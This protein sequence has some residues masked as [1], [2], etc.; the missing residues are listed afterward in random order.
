M[1]PRLGPRL[2]AG[3]GTPGRLC[4][5]LL[6]AAAAGCA[7]EPA[8]PSAGASGAATGNRVVVLA[9]AAAEM[10]EALDLLDRVVG[11]GQFGPW[12]AALE[13]L[14]AVGGYDSPNVE[15]LLE[16]DCDLLLT[17][18]SDA[19]LD[20][21]HRLRSVGIAV[22]TL[23][24]S[25]YE[26]IFDSLLRVGEIFGREADA[27][28]LERGIRAELASLAGRASGVPPRRVLVVVGRDPLYVAGPGSHVDE[29]IR[30][31]GGSNVAH[32]ALSP[33]QQLSLEV[34]L[35]RMPEVIVDLSDNRAAAPRGR[36]PGPWGEWAFLPAV[37]ENRVYWIEPARLVIPG[38]RLPEMALLMGQLIHPERFGEVPPE[39]SGDGA[40]PAREGS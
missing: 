24:T 34:V 17:A 27:R 20:A 39:I 35:E 36:L 37:R 30:L 7:D 19:A 2:L 6:L 16:L 28:E 26:G 32:D 8:R 22:E 11:V 5:V 21:H 1:A 40:G 29:L 38:L 12:P 31:V 33:Y 13:G 25:T 10:L 4:A 3:A 14:P 15:R 23:D 18:R 9:P